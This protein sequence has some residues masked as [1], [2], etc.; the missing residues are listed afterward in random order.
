MKCTAYQS[1]LLCDTRIINSIDSASNCIKDLTDIKVCRGISESALK[2]E[3]AV[4]EVM[5]HKQNQEF[6]LRSRD[7]LGRVE[8]EE[9]CYLCFS[10]STSFKKD[11]VKLS[12]TQ[13]SV[14]RLEKTKTNSC[15]KCD[16]TFPRQ[17]SL[18]HHIKSE[19]SD[20]FRCAWDECNKHFGSQS[21]LDTHMKRHLKE[22]SH[23]CNVCN[24]GFVNIKELNMHT[25]FHKPTKEFLCKVCSKTFPRQL[26][27]TNHMTLHTGAKNYFCNECGSSF[28]RLSHLKE[29]KRRT[30]VVGSSKSHSCDQCDKSFHAK[31][32]LV[33]HK[34]VHTGD[35][36]YTCSVCDK[37]FSRSHHLSK[38]T[39][40]MHDT[41]AKK[42]VESSEV[43]HYDIP[44]PSQTFVIHTSEEPQPPPTLFYH[45]QEDVIHISIQE[46][47]TFIK[48]EK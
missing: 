20:L 46:H 23:F 39:I 19:H 37:K 42:I 1:T 28:T 33:R 41:A 17:T 40:K 43:V 4:N 11:S 32:Q 24:K 6:I 27:L 13:K 18:A 14:K 26:N 35:K 21:Q 36:P 8:G 7:C 9:I 45:P 30:H 38:H 25:V 48:L 10:I 44:S 34:R 31:Q 29:H 22:F 15:L 2:P 5:I 16:A 12:E 3:I 47:Q